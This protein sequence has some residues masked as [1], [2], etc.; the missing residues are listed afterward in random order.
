MQE[1]RKILTTV[2]LKV[3][4]LTLNIPEYE[5]EVP[6]VVICTQEGSVGDL[7]TERPFIRQQGNGNGVSGIQ[8]ESNLRFHSSGVLLTYPFKPLDKVSTLFNADVSAGEI[9]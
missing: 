2:G 7:S 8:K 6:T 4:S 5:L 9:M 3:E 1:I